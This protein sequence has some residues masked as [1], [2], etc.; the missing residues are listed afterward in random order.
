MALHLSQ[1]TKYRLPQVA[2][3]DVLRTF[4]TDDITGCRW[5]GRISNHSRPALSGRPTAVEF[6]F[7]PADL[8]ASHR[9]QAYAGEY[10]QEFG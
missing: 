4:Q 1:S 7:F 8:D 3:F 9:R 2:D 6:S 10:L 5:R